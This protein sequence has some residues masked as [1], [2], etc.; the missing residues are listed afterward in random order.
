MQRPMSPP[1]CYARRVSKIS[2]SAICCCRT[3]GEGQGLEIFTVVCLV[4]I[5]GK[6]RG[7]RVGLFTPSNGGA[8]YVHTPARRPLATDRLLKHAEHVMHVKVG[9]IVDREAKVISTALLSRS[10]I[11]KLRSGTTNLIK[12][13][14]TLE[15][16]EVPQADAFR[17]CYNLAIRVD[18][19]LESQIA[20]YDRFRRHKHDH[21]DS[22]PTRTPPQR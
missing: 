12:T 1:S 19:R 2:T 16:I 6:R 17:A 11:L 15:A 10:L 22:V 5:E 13:T 21:T 8:G 3:G 7:S 20:G 4:C 9:L 18:S 14:T